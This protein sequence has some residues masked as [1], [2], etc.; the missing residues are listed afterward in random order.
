[1]N[2][3]K[4]RDHKIQ[5]AFFIHFKRGQLLHFRRSGAVSAGVMVPLVDGHFTN[6]RIFIYMN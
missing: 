4:N 2:R 3:V 1:M 5:R 6:E